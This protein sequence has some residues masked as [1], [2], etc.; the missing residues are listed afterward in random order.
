M[1]MSASQSDCEMLSFKNRERVEADKT[2]GRCGWMDRSC[3]SE[4]VQRVSGR[5]GEI[6]QSLKAEEMQSL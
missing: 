5:N 1:E 4:D 6:W 3:T 2:R